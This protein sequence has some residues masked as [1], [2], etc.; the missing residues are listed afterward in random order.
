MNLLLD[1]NVAYFLLVVGFVLAILALF[2][3][4]TGVFELVAVAALV[5]AGYGISN[6]PT[7][8]WALGVLVL[9]V[10]P[11]ILALR[12]SRQYIFLIVALAALVLGSVFLFRSRTGGWLGVNPVLAVVL[13]GLSV[14]SL[15]FA[16]RKGIEAME[17][18]VSHDP[19]RLIGSVGEARTNIFREGTIYVGGE[20]WTAR[21]DHEI[22]A[23]SLAKVIARE[24]LVLHVE[25]V[26]QAVNTDL[27]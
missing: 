11:F 5:A 3:P 23:G 13:S 16:G 24:G 26:Q 2:S 12:K 18:P 27:K 1:P 8:L 6:L 4:G 10:F 15:W 7:N 22:L 25:A 19:D 9:G 20:E 14:L 17:R 21:S